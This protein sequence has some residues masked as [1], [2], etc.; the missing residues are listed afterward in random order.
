MSQGYQNQLPKFTILDF[1]EN[2]QEI[3]HKVSLFTI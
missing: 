3:L 1:I 2:N